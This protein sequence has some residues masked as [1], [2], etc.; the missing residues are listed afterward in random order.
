MKRAAGAF[1]TNLPVSHE[2][3][4]KLILTLVRSHWCIENEL[5]GTLDTQLRED[6][7]WRAPASSDELGVK[8]LL[9]GF[10]TSRSHDRRQPQ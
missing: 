6:D 3:R 2:I 1:K 10:G 4:G 5:H 8:R 7:P 9:G